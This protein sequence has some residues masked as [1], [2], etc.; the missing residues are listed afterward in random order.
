MTAMAEDDSDF[1]SDVWRNAIDRW[2]SQH[3]KA[4]PLQKVEWFHVE[5]M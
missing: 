3:L 5:H 2:L 4:L 1:L